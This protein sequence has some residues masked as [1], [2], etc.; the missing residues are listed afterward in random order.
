MKVTSTHTIDFPTLD[1]S[2]QAGEVKDLPEDK[3]K[4]EAILENTYIRKVTSEA[5]ESPKKSETKQSSSKSGGK[6]AEDKN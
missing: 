5:K 2:I 1:W 6:E 3:E 4:Q